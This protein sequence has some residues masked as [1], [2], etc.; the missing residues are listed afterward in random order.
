MLDVMTIAE[1]ES[2]IKA[3]FAALRTGP[4]A[5]P[6]ENAL[7]RVLAADI[8]ASEFIPNFNRSTVDGYAVKAADVFGCSDSI[9]ALLALSG[10]VV[11]G[12]TTHMRLEAGQCFFVPTGG[13]VPSG[14]DAVVMLEDAEAM[15]AGTIAVYKPCAPGANLIFRGDDVKPG[16]V[17]LPKGKPLSIADIGTLA[18][19]GIISVPVMRR[20][21]VGILSTGDELAAAGE[22]LT[23]GKIRD[24]NAPML[25]AAVV[26]AGGQPHPYGILK[27]DAALITETV[28]R[29][30]AACDLLILSGGTSVGEKDTIPAVIEALGELMVHGVAAKP[31]KPTIVGAIKNKPVF[32]LPGNPVAAYFMFHL[33]ARPLI[34]AMLGTEPSEKVET[35]PLARAISSNH[36]REDL[37]PV[38]LKDGEAHP[39]IGKS[40]LISTLINTGG[41]IRI[42]RDTEGVAAGTPVEVILF[43]SQACLFNI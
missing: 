12:K 26:Q 35:M 21:L 32:G 13:E 30:A 19:L 25:S 39:V 11:M 37:V 14:S 20:P 29:A 15:G 40:G 4:E 8:P 1:V 23:L 16:Q 28:N 18:A 5:V 2:L 33:L 34:Y 31:G 41:F 9:P 24:V 36:G 6:L 3:R 7:G 10:E 38:L 27:D 42:A 43:G 22:A 17:V